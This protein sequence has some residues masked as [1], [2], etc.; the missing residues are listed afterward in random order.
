MQVSRNVGAIVE[1]RLDNTFLKK[2]VKCQVVRRNFVAYK[3]QQPFAFFI[4]RL[5]RFLV[6]VPAVR[7]CADDAANDR[8]DQGQ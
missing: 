3:D 8:A 6:P 4:P 7:P 1:F 2:Q 5:L